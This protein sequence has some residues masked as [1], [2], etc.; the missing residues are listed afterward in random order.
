MA[1]L[2]QAQNS[3]DRAENTAVNEGNDQ[4]VG[5]ARDASTQEGND[6]IKSINGSKD[7]NLGGMLG[8]FQITDKAQ[9]K[10]QQLIYQ[11]DDGSH[12]KQGRFKEENNSI[13]KYEPGISQITGDLHEKGTKEIGDPKKDAP[14]DPSLENGVYGP[15]TISGEGDN[16]QVVI[17][18][19]DASKPT[20]LS[21]EQLANAKFD[22]E[23]KSLTYT[24]A[25]GHEV[26]VDSSGKEVTKF[27]PPNDKGNTSVTRDQPGGRVTGRSY[28]NGA[29]VQIDEDGSFTWKNGLYEFR[30]DNTYGTFQRTA[31]GT[32]EL[33]S[34]V[35]DANIDNN[36]D[37]H[38]IQESFVGFHQSKRVGTNGHVV[39]D[40]SG[41]YKK[42]DDWDL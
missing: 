2:E 36:G 31:P 26:T 3:N 1:G 9:D 41:A 14:A 37:I 34:Q 27:D 11:D 16:K 33:V 7:D 38:F 8:D 15:I 20:V 23:T 22:P 40:E 18:N 32:G 10:N 24:N 19:A 12:E 39:D 21:P 35:Y 13:D 6:I 29:D 42:Y 28:E 25:E 4:Y 5:A 17:N 30:Y